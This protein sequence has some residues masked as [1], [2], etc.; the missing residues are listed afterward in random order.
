LN[1]LACGSSR[2]M[3]RMEFPSDEPSIARLA[4]WQEITQV[5]R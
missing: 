4:E 5:F 1:E 3:S 2:L